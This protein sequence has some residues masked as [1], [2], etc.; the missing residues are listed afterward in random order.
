MQYRGFKAY[1]RFCD[2]SDLK[3]SNFIM[4]SNKGKQV[5]RSRVYRK[6]NELCAEAKIN[7][8][9][10]IHTLRRSRASHSL[11]KGVSLARVS[12]M[13]RHKNPATTMLYLKITKRTYV[14]SPERVGLLFF[15]YNIFL[16]HILQI[17]QP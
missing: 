4:Y 6:L 8:R 14:H 15:Y 12:K 1:K 17:L 10:G 9:I 3:A 5:T 16:S 11:G 2:R 13:L 7:K